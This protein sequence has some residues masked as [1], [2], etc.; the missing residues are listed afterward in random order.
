M[1]PNTRAVYGET[2]GNPLVNVLDIAAVATGGPRARRAAGHRQHG[3]QPLPV[4]PAA[5]LVP[6]SWCTAPP[7]TSAATAPPWA[8]WWWKAASFLGLAA[9]NGK[10]PEMVEPSRAYHGVKFYET[11]GDFGYTMKARMEVNRTFRRQP[12]TAECLADPARH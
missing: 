3:G 11:F 2:I 6:T 9:D 1:R 5:T 8:A 7:S 4:Q 10:F 12:V